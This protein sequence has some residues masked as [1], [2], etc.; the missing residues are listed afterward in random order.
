M[1]DKPAAQARLD[2]LRTQLDTIKLPDS[3]PKG[4]CHCDANPTNFLYRDGKIT[5]VL[6][7]DQA[8]YIWLIYDIAKLIDWWTW[9]DKGEI[10]FAKTVKL[11]NAYQSVR[12][13]ATKE[14][15]HIYDALKLAVL[16]DI[17]WFFNTDSFANNRRKVE[18]L[19]NMGRQTF[20]SHLSNAQ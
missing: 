16:I 13:L 19:T 20:H 2:W 17:G 4:V 3:L 9:P 7:F 14:K 6:D 18:Y 12:P 15:D 11:L 10:D 1:N 5:A 8:S